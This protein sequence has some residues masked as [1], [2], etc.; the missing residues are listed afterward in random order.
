M[1]DAIARKKD[2]NEETENESYGDVQGQGG[3]GRVQG[4]RHPGGAVG[5]VRSPRQSDR[6]VDAQ[7]LDGLLGVFLTP[8]EK[9]E[10]QGRSAKDM[11]AK[12]GGVREI[13]TLRLTRRGL[14]T[15]HGRDAVTLAD[16][17][18]S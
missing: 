16:E 4:E 12:I 18:A 2:S 7:L 14:E 9:R 10:T 17:R 11:Q 6:A 3:S 5:E 15:W 13:R 1:G 8:A